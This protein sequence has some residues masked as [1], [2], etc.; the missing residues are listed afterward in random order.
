MKARSDDPRRCHGD[1]GHPAESEIDL[2][3]NSLGT[4]GRRILNRTE[5]APL[6][7]RP[8]VTL[9]T[10]TSLDGRRAGPGDDPDTGSG[11]FVARVQADLRDEH[12]AVLVGVGTILT[13]NPD[14]GRQI[15]VAPEEWRILVLDTDLRTPNTATIVR[16]RPQHTTIVHSPDATPA[17]RLRLAEAGVGLLEM[18]SSGDG[19]VAIPPLLSHLS[20][21]GTRTLLVEGGPTVQG[22]FVDLGLADEAVLCLRPHILGG[23]A[24]PAIGGL[25]V[26]GIKD[27]EKLRIDSVRRSGDC[28]VI[29]ASR[30]REAGEAGSWHDD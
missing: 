17:D 5:R 25:G 14:L 30:K 20:K 24:P 23:E 8:W 12:H 21:E 18:P 15:D 13:D 19:R 2:D 27:A 1:L 22:S 3:L 26:R 4:P 16:N 6:E 28:L 9:F 29:R 11:Q 7:D 10:A